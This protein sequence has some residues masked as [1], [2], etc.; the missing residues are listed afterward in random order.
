[1]DAIENAIRQSKKGDIIIV[2]GKGEEDYQKV[3]G[4]YEYYE[5]DISVVRR[6]MG[7]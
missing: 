6:M 3:N 2:A 7:A 1:M 4:K 5:S